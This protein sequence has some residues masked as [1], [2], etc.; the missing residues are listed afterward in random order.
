M[1][2]ILCAIVLAIADLKKLLWPD[3][4]ILALGL[5]LIMCLALWILSSLKNDVSL[6]I[7][8]Y[9]P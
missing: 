3:L 2:K 6:V 1:K 7:I 5:C 4:I 9:L 8:V